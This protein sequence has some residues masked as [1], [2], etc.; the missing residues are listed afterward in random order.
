MA[1]ITTIVA[2]PAYGRQR[3]YTVLRFAL[4]VLAGGDAINIFLLEDAIFSA[5][6][7][8]KPSGFTG[9][10]DERMP[11]CEKLM[12]ASLEQGATIRICTVCAR[13]RGLKKEELIEGVKMAGM[14]DLVQWVVESD[15]VVSF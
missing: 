4:T 13:E 12:K 3:I 1:T 11:D 10:P 2:D 7:D 9:V 5:K 6:K 14:P 8:Q 15:K